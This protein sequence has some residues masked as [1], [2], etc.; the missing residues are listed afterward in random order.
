MNIHLNKASHR[1]LS[2]GNAQAKVK[3]CILFKIEYLN[4]IAELILLGKKNRISQVI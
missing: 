1:N 2:S 4:G 3:K